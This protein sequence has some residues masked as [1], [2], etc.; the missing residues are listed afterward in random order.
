M[1]GYHIFPDQICYVSA[2]SEPNIELW[3]EEVE[4]EKKKK[5]SL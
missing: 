4:W 2:W 1:K 5:K 3:W